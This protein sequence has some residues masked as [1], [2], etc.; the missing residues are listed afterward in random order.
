MV[1]GVGSGFGGV[2]VRLLWRGQHAEVGLGRHARRRG[3]PV[4]GDVHSVVMRLGV[5]G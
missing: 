2:K 3:G 4:V 1:V 5:V